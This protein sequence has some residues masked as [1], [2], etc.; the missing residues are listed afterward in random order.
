MINLREMLSTIYADKTAEELYAWLEDQQLLEPF[1][2]VVT[3]L[4]AIISE[5]E[6]LL[7]SCQ[8]LP[9]GHIAANLLWAVNKRIAAEG[10][11]ERAKVLE[12]ALGD[13]CLRVLLTFLNSIKSDKTATWMQINYALEDTCNFHN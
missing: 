12:N 6:K 5:E 2:R 10:S 3:Q 7:K 8:S 1:K 4:N 13:I 9:V 11:P